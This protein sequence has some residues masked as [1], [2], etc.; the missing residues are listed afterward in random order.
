[1]TCN[2]SRIT[3]RVPVLAIAGLLALLPFSLSAETGRDIQSHE[4]RLSTPD[5]EVTLAGTLRLP[6][7]AR[8]GI[9][10][11]MITG[12]GDHKRDAIISGTPLFRLK[13]EA[14]AAAGIASLRLDDRGTGEST[15]PSTRASTTADRVVDMRAALDWL[16]A[17]EL[18]EFSRVGV[19][20]HSEG[21]GIGARLAAQTNPPDFLILLGTP[22]LQG[23]E[24]WVDQQVAGFRQSVG[25]EAPE[26]L[27]Q[28]EAHMR[29]AARLSIAGAA[30]EA[31]QENTIAL[32]ALGGID[33]N[34]EENNHM[35]E[36]FTS[37]M[38][39]RW[40]RHFLADNPAQA[41]A[42][43]RVPVLA[44]YGSH[45]RLT[46]AAANAGPLVEALVTAGNPDFTVQIMPDQDHFFL[47][48]P[49][50]PVGEHAFGEMELPTEVM[51]TVIAW[52]R[53]NPGP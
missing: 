16:R 36:G 34:A 30:P 44:I 19:I 46:S 14:L 26:I 1:M 49:G 53:R 5:P 25:I 3:H 6:D 12:S 22:A 50:R 41:L 38:A 7:S 48:A 20:G 32:F 29:E 37:R 45:D 47:R 4:V 2:R 13:A 28:V 35:L 39:D 51:S 52:L 23:K 21:A 40:M 15:G 31:M 9:V 11:L 42:A 33:V 24:V 27:A 10:V 18:A 8:N 43:T 17:G